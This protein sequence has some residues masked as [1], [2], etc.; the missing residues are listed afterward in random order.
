[1]ST[2]LQSLR[3]ACERKN[4]ILDQ[5]KLPGEPKHEGKWRTAWLQIP[6]RTRVAIRRLHRQF[7]HVPNRFLVQLLRIS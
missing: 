2:S 6:L 5:T 7:G 3:N 4:N 1:M